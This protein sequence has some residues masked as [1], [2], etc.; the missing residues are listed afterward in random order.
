MYEVLKKLISGGRSSG[1]TGLTE[2]ELR[3]LHRGF[4]IEKGF[5]KSRRNAWLYLATTAY[6]PTNE[7]DKKPVDFMGLCFFC[8]RSNKQG[9]MKPESG[10]KLDRGCDCE[11]C[12]C[13]WL[14]ANNQEE[15]ES[16][17]RMG[18]V[19]IKAGGSDSSSKNHRQNEPQYSEGRALIEA[20]YAFF[21]DPA[22]LAKASKEV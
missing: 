15:L 1:L 17:D 7:E 11:S 13:R 20:R 21:K 3:K 8:S 12:S 18:A 14:G 10:K 22:Y 5:P 6:T 16:Q 2:I 9:A 19:G 4:E